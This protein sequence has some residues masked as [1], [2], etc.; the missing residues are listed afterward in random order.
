MHPKLITS[1]WAVAVT[2]VA[3][4]TI[5][6][7]RNL[8]DPDRS[9]ERPDVAPVDDDD[10][11]PFE[12]REQ[13]GIAV[14]YNLQLRNDGL[15]PVYRAVLIIRNTGSMAISVTPQLTL[16]DGD[17]LVIKPYSFE[18]LRSDA[19]ALAGTTAPPIPSSERARYYQ[20]AVTDSST[21]QT[22]NY[23]GQSTSA[24]SF[25]NGFAKGYAMGAQMRAQA[26]AANGF[27]LVKWANNHWLNSQYHYVATGTAVSGAIMYPGS[28]KPRLPM[29]LV[30]QLGDEKFVFVTKS[31]K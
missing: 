14:S 10:D 13:N 28:K 17:G 16:L 26:D 11:I 23:T 31:K 30:V 12:T 4:Q 18:G 1:V 27:T 15:G 22:F 24:G 29:Q 6:G 5:A 21:G 7:P 20:G 19:F 9:V 2:L 3:G 25:S 8:N